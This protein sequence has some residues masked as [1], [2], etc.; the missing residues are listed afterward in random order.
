MPFRSKIPARA[1][2]TPNQ[3]QCNSITFYIFLALQRFALMAAPMRPECSGSIGLALGACALAVPASAQEVFPPASA[4][5]EILATR[6][7]T[8]IRVDGLLDEPSWGLANV[9][10]GF[11]QSDPEQGQPATHRTYVRILFDDDI[12]YIAAV[13]EQS[14]ESIR[15]QN[16]QRDFAAR[17]NDV[18]TVAIDG[19]VD[20]RKAV[21]FQVSPFGNQADMEVTDGED[22][23]TDWDA[24]WNARTTLRDDR[25]TVEMAI[26]WRN[27]R[28]RTGSDRLGIILS[29]QVRSLNE[30][31][32]IPPIP[33]VMSVYRMSYEAI[34]R[35]IEPPPPGRNLQI[36]PYVLGQAVSGTTGLRPGRDAEI[37]GEIKWA[38]TP[39]T[40]VD[41]TVNTDFAQA[42]VDRQFVNLDRFSVF[43]PERRQFFLE[44]AG[45]FDAGVTNWIRPFFTRRI[46]LDD[47]GLPIPITAGIR[48]TG[49][50]PAQ[51]FGVI[52]M[53]QEAVRGLPA[54][55]FGVARYSKNIKEQSRVGGMV[56]YRSDG[57]SA[58]HPFGR[59]NRT[60]T[61]DGLWRPGPSAGVQ[62]MVSR[63]ADSLSG[64]GTGAQL[65]AYYETSSVYVGLLEY[66]NRD[67]NPGVGLEL[68]DANYV[69][70]SPA[71]LWDLRGD[72]LPENIRSFNPAISVY[73]FN[74]SDGGD[75]KFGYAVIQ[76]LRF[77]FHS[78]AAVGVTVEP[79]WQ[80]ITGRFAPAG[81]GIETGDYDY[82]RYRVNAN[83]DRSRIFS[84]ET[85]YETGGY[86]D[87][88][89]SAY[90]VSGR[91][92]PSPRFELTAD[93]E[94]NR[95]DRLG[96]MDQA[97]TTR[98]IGIGSRFAF[99][100]RLQL[101]GF[102][103]H[104]S[105]MSKDILNARLSWEFRP[106]S[107]LYVVYNS[108]ANDEGL[109]PD[110]SRQQLLIKFTYL[111]EL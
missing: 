13:C 101:S 83:S 72:W 104:N 31:V 12:L 92:A 82:T 79:N 102:L 62:A 58:T 95:L 88:R 29:R 4:P 38:V 55:D 107:Y 70:H 57:A 26:P 45:T 21:V 91:Y 63:S 71:V 28:Y 75:L 87:G 37:G 3:N 74:S 105:L 7:T 53:R 59:T 30:I 108:S 46:G 22:L 56:T 47:S 94:L 110:Y 9:I 111:L 65:W 44:S 35:G 20:Q 14:R 85:S 109:I 2:G 103:Q 68:L 18:F 23:N 50:S 52:A 78:G 97:R 54:S 86:Y 96:P 10:T 34:L 76:P 11:T 25:W 42:D 24:R 67:Y 36:A 73:S 69:M 17:E 43:L 33:R 1:Y 90:S 81:I 60:F 106:L 84:G 48:S 15:V 64:D 99:N 61:V 80:R 93:F 66:F 8:P 41:F 40:V 51:E 49:R 5:L 27:F 39:G 32:S 16:L 77:E 98:L 89:L 6:T 100:P 19:F